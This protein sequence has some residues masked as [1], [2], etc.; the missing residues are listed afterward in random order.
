MSVKLM[1][2]SC[3][4][5]FAKGKQGGPEGRVRQDVSAGVSLQGWDQAGKERKGR[6]GRVALGGRVT[7]YY[8]QEVWQGG[9]KRMESRGGSVALGGRISVALV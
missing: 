6:G 1:F 3:C 7:L 5:V 8:T 2:M 4:L 9:A